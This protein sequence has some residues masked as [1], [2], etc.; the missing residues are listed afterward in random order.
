M[1]CNNPVGAIEII[2]DIT[3]RKTAETELRQSEEMLRLIFDTTFEGI[4][5]YEEI[6]EENRWFLLDS[7]ERYCE[8]AGRSKEELLKIGDTRA[9]QRSIENPVSEELQSSSRT[10]KAYTGVFSWNR[11]DGKE[12]IIEFIAAQT[13][14]GER[15]LTIGFDRDI[16][17][18]KTS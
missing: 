7:N 16:T 8:M 5:I 15:H 12:N 10:G 14:V 2:R 13:R 11:P 6:P 9:L 4:C 1:L 3:D 17:E 18:R